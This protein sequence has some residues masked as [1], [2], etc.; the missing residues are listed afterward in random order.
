MAGRSPVTPRTFTTTNPRVAPRKRAERVTLIV[1]RNK[2]R[3]RRRQRTSRRK[4]EEG[5]GRT[6]RG[7]AGCACGGSDTARDRDGTVK[8]GEGGETAPTPPRAAGPAAGSGAPAPGTRPR[9]IA[10]QQS[11][12]R[13][14]KRLRPHRLRWR[15]QRPAWDTARL[16]RGSQ[17][18]AGRGRRALVSFA[19]SAIGRWAAHRGRE[20]G[21]ATHRMPKY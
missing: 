10:P 4:A 1:A 21:A 8:R 18:R 2:E 5:D 12:K 9:E 20:G 6:L 13:R 11:K 14:G 16:Q 7:G 19:G 17:R 15:R 3:Q